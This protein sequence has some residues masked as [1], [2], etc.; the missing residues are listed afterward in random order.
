MTPKP[1]AGMTTDEAEQ[2]GRWWLMRE[3]AIEI[4]VLAERQLMEAGAIEPNDRRFYNRDEWRKLRR[5]T[6]S[7]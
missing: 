2:L 3:N 5:L 1:I 7:R 6:S 4:G